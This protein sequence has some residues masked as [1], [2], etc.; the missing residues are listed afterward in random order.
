M[1]IR[2]LHNALVFF[3]QAL[4]MNLVLANTFYAIV[5][6]IFGFCARGY[7][8]KHEQLQHPWPNI[9]GQK[10]E[11]GIFGCCENM[12]VACMSCCCPAIRAGMNYY[13]AGWADGFLK[14]MIIVGILFGIPG[15]VGMSVLFPLV[16]LRGRLKIRQKGN[17]QRDTCADCCCVCMCP[18]FVLCQ[19]ARHIDKCMA[20]VAQKKLEE[21]GDLI[22][23]AIEVKGP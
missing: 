4:F 10:F 19:E 11:S 9:G 21:S 13:Y 23:M 6:I 17:L 1:P 8:N 3:E 7:V 20:H 12:N 5:M 16:L 18:L 2:A 22:G 14:P 15:F